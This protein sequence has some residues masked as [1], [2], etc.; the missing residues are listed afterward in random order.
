MK[1]SISLKRWLW[2]LVVFLWLVPYP[3]L[4]R[5][6]IIGSVGDDQASE[7]KKFLPF[8]RYLAKQL[9]SAEIDDDKV[10]VAKDFS[11]MAAMLR[12]GKV[13][14]YI[15]SP[16]PAVA[17][18]RLSGSKFLLRRW[19]KGVGEYH[20]VIFVRKDSGINQMEELKGKQIAFESPSSSSGYFLPKLAMTQAGLKLVGQKNPSP[21]EVAYLFS[22]EDENTMWWV[23][24]GKVTAGAMDQ[25]NFEQEAKGEI[26]QLKIL[27][28][29]FSIPRQI[30]SH[31]ADLSEPLVAKIKQVLTQ[32]DKS[33][34]GKKTL[35]AFERT[36]KFDELTAQS[37]AP[38]VQQ[39]KLIDAE[40]GK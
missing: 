40:L 36:A 21:N 15:D 35:Q 1:I 31:R 16:F 14:L 8:A 37:M 2:G 27:H 13:D 38:L 32:M 5:P 4:A 7:I 9:Q 34:E 17:A 23:I 30:V 22:E 28:K 29:T 10:A 19:K 12:D 3:A 20:S 11:Q 39:H 6:L 25:A 26:G 24:K 18:S 33:E